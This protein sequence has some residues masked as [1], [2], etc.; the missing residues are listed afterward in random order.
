MSLND[1]H[2]NTCVKKRVIINDDLCISL[3]PTP[4][5]KWIMDKISNQISLHKHEINDDEDDDFDQIL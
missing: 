5:Q 4:E 3:V 1:G 2:F